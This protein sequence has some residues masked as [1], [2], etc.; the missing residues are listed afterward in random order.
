M[1]CK[2]FMHRDIH[3]CYLLNFPFCSNQR[4]PPFVQSSIKIVI[5]KPLSRY[6][7]TKAAANVSNA[8]M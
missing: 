3:H 6:K 2:Y 7:Q 8:A 1:S 5:I 4:L